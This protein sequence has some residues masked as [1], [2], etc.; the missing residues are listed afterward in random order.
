MQYLG[1]LPLAPTAIGAINAL[2]ELVNV[3]SK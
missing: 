2:E 3:N 1:D